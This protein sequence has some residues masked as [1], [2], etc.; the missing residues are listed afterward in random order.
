[1][2]K[3]PRYAVM[4]VLMLI[5]GSVTALVSAQDDAFEA[6]AETTGVLVQN[7]ESAVITANEDGSFSLTLQN[8]DNFSQWMVSIP[9]EITTSLYR[10]SEVELDWNAADL[11]ANG[12]LHTSDFSLGG[13][14]SAPI[15]NPDENSFTYTFAIDE[16]LVTGLEIGKSGLELPDLMEDVS[17][18][19]IL[20]PDFVTDLIQAREARIASARNFGIQGCLI[21]CG[22]RN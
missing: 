3:T 22:P 6:P 7:A 2:L 18:F 1:M 21:N 14:L 13:E 16:D 19:I 12:T 17:L 10:S 11:I 15:F 5:L 9:G 4:L 20:N 8:V